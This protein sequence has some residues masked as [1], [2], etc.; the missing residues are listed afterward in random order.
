MKAVDI[1][2]EELLEKLIEGRLSSAERERL[3]AHLKECSACRFELG[4]R[5]DLDREA[6]VLSQRPQLTRAAQRAPGPLPL[7]VGSPRPRTRRRWPLVLLAAA[8]VLCAGGATAAVLAGALPAPRWLSWSPAPSA[9]ERGFPAA[10]PVVNAR[11]RAS[12]AALTVAAIVP[13]TGSAEP[14]AAADANGALAAPRARAEPAPEAAAAAFGMRLPAASA[15]GRARSLAVRGHGEATAPDSTLA[16]RAPL[17]SPEPR[18]SGPAE[19]LFAEANRARR[20]GNVERA[21]ELYRALQAQYAGSSESQLSRALLAQML[22][23][24]GRPADALAGFDDYLAEGS[25]V[26]SAEALVGRARALEEL[27]EPA[28]ADAAWKR[29]QSRYPGSVHARLAAARLLARGQ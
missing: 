17:A 2:P 6:P 24:H 27:G 12:K 3:S 1:H 18:A 13:S 15:L 11:K 10:S 25:P 9:S 14:A 23:E 5:A 28:E 4:V 26:L 7:A 20:S 8:M 19:S 21:A 29:V 16:A 22:L